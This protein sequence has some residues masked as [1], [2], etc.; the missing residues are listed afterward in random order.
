MGISLTSQLL[1]LLGV[2][3][4]LIN[5]KGKKFVLREGVDG[6][7]IASTFSRSIFIPTHHFLVLVFSFSLFQRIWSE[8]AV[9]GG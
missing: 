3:V 7:K 5:Q 9:G 4:R 2:Y 8:N 6:Q 1:L